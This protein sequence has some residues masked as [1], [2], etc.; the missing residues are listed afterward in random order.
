MFYLI[1]KF[2]SKKS[3]D[4]NSFPGDYI[5]ME[6]LFIVYNFAFSDSLFNFELKKISGISSIYCN[7]FT[8]Q[9]K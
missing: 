9:L 1:K 8:F 5:F 4:G 6:I 2:T 7:S 3:L